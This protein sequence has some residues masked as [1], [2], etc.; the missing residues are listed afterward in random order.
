MPHNSE[1]RA[2]F[3]LKF[4]RCAQGTHG[5]FRYQFLCPKLCMS[6]CNCNDWFRYIHQWTPIFIQISEHFLLFLVPC[7][8]I[9][10]F[11]RAE[12][13]NSYKS[14]INLS[15][16]LAHGVW[17]GTTVLWFIQTVE[18]S[19]GTW[20][21]MTVFQC[22]SRKFFCNSARWREDSSNSSF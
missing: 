14:T 19:E 18:K 16:F 21:M 4:Y 2:A 17:N 13:P 1:L 12:C 15:E 10:T 7:Q 6:L 22:N 20:L 8:K 3:E 9:Q 11:R 5:I